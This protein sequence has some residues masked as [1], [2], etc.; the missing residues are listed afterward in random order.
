MD[1]F[2]S[3]HHI[4]IIKQF[5]PNKELVI[6][7]YRHPNPVRCKCFKLVRKEEEKRERGEKNHERLSG[8]YKYNFVHGQKR[9]KDTYSKL[10]Q[11]IYQGSLLC[12][13]G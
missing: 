11:G 10:K 8:N 5:R 9:Q 7:H 4:E 12:I 6:T 1:A 2:L 13:I 3:Q